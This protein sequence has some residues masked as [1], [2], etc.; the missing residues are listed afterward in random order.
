VRPEKLAGVEQD[1]RPIGCERRG[2]HDLG[3]VAVAFI[4]EGSKPGVGDDD[5]GIFELPTADSCSTQAAAEARQVVWRALRI[6]PPSKVVAGFEQS[7]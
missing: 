3:E 1:Q 7:S 5:V 6:L 2:P 4:N